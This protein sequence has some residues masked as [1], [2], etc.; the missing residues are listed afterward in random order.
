MS[1]DFRFVTPEDARKRLAELNRSDALFKA[2]EANDHAEFERL[3]AERQALTR[4]IAPPEHP[5]QHIKPTN[6][7]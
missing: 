2:R 1:T 4:I 5:R 3:M 6:Y 7:Y